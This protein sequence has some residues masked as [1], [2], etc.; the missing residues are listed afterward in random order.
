[1]RWY[2]NGFDIKFSYD[3]TKLK[4]SNIET[5]AITDLSQVFIENPEFL[6]WE[7]EFSGKMDGFYMAET[8]DGK[9]TIEMFSA[10]VP[11]FQETEHIKPTGMIDGEPTYSIDTKEDVLF[12]KI[13]FKL[14]VEELDIE[15]YFG[16][17][18]TTGILKEGFVEIQLTEDD[19]FNQLS[20][21]RFI[22]RTAS[23]DATLKTLVLSKGETNED[24]DLNT[25]K[26]YE[27]TPTFDGTNLNYTRE[28]LEYI[29]DLDLKLQTND[30]KA[31]VKMKIPKRDIDTGELIYLED[32]TLDYEEKEITQ[33]EN[34]AKLNIKLNELGKEN[35]KITII[36]TSESKKQ[37]NEYI[38]D[39]KRPFATIKGN[40][41]TAP[42]ATIEKYTADIKIYK[43]EEVDA[44]IDIADSSNRTKIHEALVGLKSQDYKTKEDGTY[45]IYVIPGKYDMLID[46]V[47]Y[48][49]HIYTFGNLSEGDTKEL[50][51]KDLIAGD[52]NKD[53]IV[54]A[55]DTALI[56]SVYGI[57]KENAAFADNIACDF[58]EDEKINAVDLAIALSNYSSVIKIEDIP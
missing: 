11:P 43:S 37:T 30:T 9:D 22:D 54:N 27:L 19:I 51:Q 25:Y 36:V 13:S 56:K 1:M 44:V 53:G 41:Y 48:I 4:L 21:F 10:L 42:T 26:E 20:T 5:N 17:E 47:G 3:N 39:I 15:N 34:G 50:G 2:L 35:T 16:V 7:T 32:G 57:G 40:V 55:I 38:I 14:L 12:A 45:E 58:N 18:K 46:K 24:P 23:D 33:D 49:D 6:N 8:I 28:I 52:I 29:D 31:S